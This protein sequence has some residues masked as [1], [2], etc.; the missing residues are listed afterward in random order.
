VTQGIPGRRDGLFVLRQRGLY[1]WIELVNAQLESESQ[2]ELLPRPE[3]LLIAADFT[4]I[5]TSVEPTLVGLYADMLLT[6]L[7][8]ELEEVQ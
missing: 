2:D 7:R 8:N 5:T 4:P 1:A 3:R 6:K